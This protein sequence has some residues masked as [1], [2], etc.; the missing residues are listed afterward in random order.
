MSTTVIF[1]VGSAMF[2]LTVYGAVM[3]AGIALTR[4]FYSQNDKYMERPGFEDAGAGKPDETPA[5]DS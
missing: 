1:I 4:S 3:G 5:A 2:A